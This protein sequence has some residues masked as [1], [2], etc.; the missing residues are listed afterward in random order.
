MKERFCVTGM[1]CSACSSHVHKSVE[2]LNG[3]IEVQ[4]NLL[5]ESMEVSYDEQV[6]Q[7][8]QICHAVEQAGYG[9]TPMKQVP[10][11]KPKKKTDAMKWRLVLSIAFMI[12]LMYVAMAPG[13]HGL[14]WLQVLLLLPIL[15][16]NKDYFWNGFKRLLR[17]APNMDTLI[18]LGATASVGYSVFILIYEGVEATHSG[19][20]LYFESA[21]MILTMITIGKYLETL[22]KSRTSDAIRKLMELAP[23]TAIVVGEDGKETEIPAEKLVQGQVFLLKPGSLVPADGTVIE[24]NSSI[25]ESAVTGESIPVEKHQGD[26]VVSATLNKAGFLKCRAER[27]GENTTLAQIIRLVEEASASK[28]P[29]ARLADKVASIFV[30]VVMLIALV[31]F[32]AWMIA[33]SEVAFAISSAIAVLVISCPCALGLAT[34]VAIMVGT[35][36]G[37]KHGILIKSGEALQRAHEARTLVLDKTGTITEGKL[38]V[39]RVHMVAKDIGKEN[40]VQLAAALEKLSEHPLAEAVVTYAEECHLM[41]PQ[42]QNFSAVPG[43][44]IYGEV[45]KGEGDGLKC[46]V[47]NS[48]FMEEHQIPLDEDYKHILDGMAEDGLTPLLVAETDRLLGLIGVADSVRST[49]AEAIH[50]CKKLG[51]HVVMLTGDNRKT[52]EAV[53]RSLEID[54]VVAEVLPQEKEKKIRKLQ[55]TGHKVIMVGDGINDAPALAAADVGVAIG[56]GT[57]VAMES[58]DIVL[59]KSDLQD[60]VTA[61][62]LSRHVIRNIK[63]NLFWAFFY[64][65]IGIPLAAG[66]LYPAFGIRLTPM[67]GSVA[68]SLSSLFVVSNALRLRRFKGVAN[69]EARLP[70]NVNQENIREESIKDEKEEQ[71]KENQEDNKMNAN[72]K[73]M[74]I[75]GMMCT[76]CTGRVQKVLEALDGV[77]TVVMSLEDKTA[78]V[79]M[80]ADVSDEVLTAAVTDAGYT[81]VEI[82]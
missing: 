25:D 55:A 50:R 81:V 45:T 73:V 28:A 22:S 2:K 19:H 60:A 79:E 46:F 59:M 5:T 41:L 4:V 31:T 75:D 67:F 71:K 80:V 44:G 76:H 42:V 16:L 53:K 37:A 40:L 1:T 10:E 57:D 56:A 20:A 7:A 66:L 29:I 70:E 54:E 61:I 47:G 78:T 39:A 32:C 8:Q 65:A 18:A 69:K 21:G 62:D 26:T 63:E 38:R 24:G 13:L 11:Q 49:S 14:Y 27:V 3:V 30:P 64:N 15:V 74:V 52:A 34:P 68:M 23:K 6:L 58:A 17:G 33:G 48:A 9:A 43:R 82:R 36:V 77:S 72:K 12:P 51:I 35:G